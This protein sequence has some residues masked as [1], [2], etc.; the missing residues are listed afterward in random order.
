ML[1]EL[2]AHAFEDLDEDVC[3]EVAQHIAE[4]VRDPDKKR[5][6]WKVG[7][8]GLEVFSALFNVLLCEDVEHVSKEQAV[9]E[10]FVAQCK[11]NDLE[12]GACPLRVAVVAL[13][14]VETEVEPRFPR[15]VVVVALSH[16]VCEVLGGFHQSAGVP[17]ELCTHTQQ[18]CTL[19]AEVFADV[20]FA[21][22]R[23]RAFQQLEDLV[24][25]PC[26]RGRRRKKLRQY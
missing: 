12:N 5:P 13:V 8:N 11:S 14:A 4:E 23:N 3:V 1:R 2:L 25:S 16:A 22:F 10:G 18:F 21:Q 9:L 19:R 26:R 24:Q 17:A 15:L 7:L 20:R 6:Q